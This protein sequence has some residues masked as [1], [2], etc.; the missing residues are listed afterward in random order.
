MEPK[1]KR[2]DQ[3]EELTSALK[4]KE[5]E[6][7]ALERRCYDL[8]TG[9]ESQRW[10]VDPED[11]RFA[12][13][14]AGEAV[15]WM[16]EDGRF[17]YVNEEACRSLGYTRE[18]L[19]EGVRLW[20]IDPFYSEEEYRKAWAEIRGESLE[21]YTQESY[22]KRKDGTLFPVEVMAKHLTT[23]E[24][25]VHVAFVRDITERKRVGRSLHLT[26]FA[27]DHASIACFWIT[28]DGRLAYVNEQACASLGY[29]R[30][31]ILKKPLT[32]IDTDFHPQTW[33]HFW[34]ALVEAGVLSYESFH[35]HKEGIDFPVEVTAN[36]VEFEDAHY[37]CAFVTDVSERR[38]AEKE[39]LRLESQLRQAQKMEAI[40]SLAGGIAHD[41]NN[42][43]FPI[44][45]F[46]EMVMRK[47]PTGSKEKEN[48]EHVL[49][50]TL[51][52][53][54][55]VR[56]I[57]AFSRQAS[58]ETRPVFVGNEVAEV[59]KLIRSS[60]P[61]TIDI[62]TS[63]PKG[64]GQILADPTQIH[65]ITM[66]LV[67]NAYHA[68]EQTGGTL[69]VSVREVTVA[70]G[71]TI[72]LNL[73]EGRYAC[74]LVADT[75]IGM[76]KD[77]RERIFDPYFTTKNKEEGTG[78]GLSVVHGIVKTLDG[79]IAVKSAPGQGTEFQVYLPLTVSQVESA[80]PEN[81]DDLTGNEHI[82]IVDDE[83]EIVSALNQALGDLGYQVTGRS[84]SLTAFE[85][86]KEDPERFDLLISDMMMPRLTGDHL[87]VLVRKIRPDLPVILLTGFKNKLVLERASA[88][89][90]DRVLTK[91]LRREDLAKAVR[92]AFG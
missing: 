42:I 43:L 28:R 15:F 31:E 25:W 38:H 16:A 29:T 10:E 18:E 83:V 59:I 8:Q 91:P 49:S 23:G 26:Q 20:D 50:A 64:A 90:V 70:E 9:N 48:L 88:V 27:I 39:R 87:A 72:E 82:L 21:T 53:K 73:T 51:R 92:A 58:G 85:T 60:L 80:F 74:M 89:G 78:L 41:F 63:L 46:T 65:Q 55:L 13:D 2:E 17:I 44:M 4:Q 11:F 3:I 22:H 45:S 77:I 68:M 34:N 30:E 19:I 79:E 75:G 86:F 37:C 52:A 6:L 35:R 40:G 57:L 54:D 66:N 1:R 76:N 5:R 36:H 24:R 56:Q 61:S 7:T 14:H 33:D 84:D 32:E 71:D 67:T 62:A 12:M 69:T 81:V 47:L